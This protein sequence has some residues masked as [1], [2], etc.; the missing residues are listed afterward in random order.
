MVKRWFMT[1]FAEQPSPA[2]LTVAAEDLD[3]RMRCSHVLGVINEAEPVETATAASVRE[4]MGP[5]AT[6]QRQRSSCCPDKQ[7]GMHG[8]GLHGGGDSQVL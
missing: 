6:C 5:H 8:P 7:H 3:E 4:W 1:T 2:A